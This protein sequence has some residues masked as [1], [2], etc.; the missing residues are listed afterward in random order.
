MK[1]I[2]EKRL[3]QLRTTGR[4]DIPLSVMVYS[5]ALVVLV[6][7]AGLGVAVIAT[8]IF[9]SDD[10]TDVVT[11]P[12]AWLGLGFALVFGGVL[13]PMVVQ[14]LLHT[15]ALVITWD[16]IGEYHVKDGKRTM[17][18]EF[19]WS[20]IESVSGRY[21][22]E[23]WPHRGFY[24]VF[25][26]LTPD[27]YARYVDTLPPANRRVL[28]NLYGK[29]DVPMRSFTGGPKA[30]HQLLDRAHREFGSPLHEHR[31]RR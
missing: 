12:Y 26:A 20:D 6:L 18:W 5:V 22:G 31:A 11:E 27:R 14:I 3:G 24:N 25:L 8:V 19:S 30:L 4:V 13:V 2:A 7:L 16:G 21:L 28:Q 29:R 1:K 17:L 9:E 15:S 23:R 10:W